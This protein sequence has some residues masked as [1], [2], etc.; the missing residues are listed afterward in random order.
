M[1]LLSVLELLENDKRSKNETLEDYMAKLI[2]KSVL[3]KKFNEKI[4]KYAIE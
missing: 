4:R 3:A 1:V 2:I